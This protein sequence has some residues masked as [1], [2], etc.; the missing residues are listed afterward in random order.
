MAT[1]L[2][3]LNVLDYS[4]PFYGGVGVHLDALGDEVRARNHQLH[5]AFPRPCT[6]YEEAAIHATTVRTLPSIR[7]PLWRGFAGSLRHL[8][9]KEHVDVVHLHFSYA[10]AL[11][12]AVQRFGR[13]P[14]V[15]HWH[16][17]PKALLSGAARGVGAGDLAP[18]E[19]KNGGPSA[20]LSEI[21][22]ARTRARRWAS[23]RI[24]RIG[25]N[26]IRTHVVIST[27]IRDLL[28]REQW[29]E[30]EKMLYLPNTLPSLP[31][32]PA[33]WREDPKPF[34]LGSVANFRG[35]KD[36]ATLLR[37]FS[38]C[39][40]E[41]SD[42]RLDLV[43]DGETR[44]RM[45]A[46]AREL[47]IAAQ[48]R[49]LGQVR[50]PAPVYRQMDAFVLSTHYEG[51]ALSVLEAMAHGLPVI[52]T[53]LPSTRETICSEEMGLLVPPKDPSALAEA[54][55]RIVKE[56]ERRRSLGIQARR[57][58]IVGATPRDWAA[59]LCDLYARIAME[60]RG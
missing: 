60:N 26:A 56:P 10:M 12:L 21:H 39:I 22:A 51:H 49:F 17:P 18:G 34:V 40:Q 55:S 16:N 46:L 4:P 1:E 20:L 30:P 13:V 48:V 33:E 36:H 5:L 53:D 41:V 58:A 32:A 45:E 8:V 42:L 2:S 15:Y 25:D 28:Q 50:D 23:G 24:A 31:R 27:E 52:A 37:A 9:R 29:T 7:R 54:I 6:W 14:V 3:I 11:A 47:G 59:N 44:P 19:R 35:Q 57:A 38:R 43:G